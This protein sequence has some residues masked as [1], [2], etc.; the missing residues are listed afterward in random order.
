MRTKLKLFSSSL[1]DL[2]I[3]INKKKYNFP[4]SSY[5]EEESHNAMM[6]IMTMIGSFESEQ[7]K[8]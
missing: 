8:V 7:S 1:I 6:T 3:R 4:C 2:S 5:R